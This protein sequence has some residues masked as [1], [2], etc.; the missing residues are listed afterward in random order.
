MHLRVALEKLTGKY[1]VPVTEAVPRV[2]YR[3]TIRKPVQKRGRH[4]KQSGGH[5]QFG[6]VML[7]IEPRERGSGIA[8]TESISGGVVPRQYFSSVETG[9]RDYLEAGGP[10][11][12]PVVD[13]QRT[14]AAGLR[15]EDEHRRSPQV[16]AV[17]HAG[18]SDDEFLST[19]AVDVAEREARSET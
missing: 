19:V 14:A 15:V 2:P 3:E 7:T 8:F 11:G 16:R 4:K 18:R 1:G 17:P 12:F 9:V 6:D 13:E 10:P 5:G